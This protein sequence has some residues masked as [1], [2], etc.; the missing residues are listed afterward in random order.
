MVTFDGRVWGISAGCGRLLLAKDFAHDTF[1]LTLNR[2][3]S[4]LTSLTVELNHTTLVLYPSLQVSLQEQGEGGRV[5]R[6][7]RHFPASCHV[8]TPVPRGDCHLSCSAP[9][10]PTDLQAVQLLPACGELSGPGSASCQDQE[11]PRPQDRADQ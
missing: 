8:H 4:G 10:W 5:G 3:G 9:V 6:S 7:P 2:A 1:S 11:G